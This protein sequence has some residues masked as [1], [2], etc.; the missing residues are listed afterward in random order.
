MGLLFVPYLKP[1]EKKCAK[2]IFKRNRGMGEI[3]LS[4]DDI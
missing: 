2:E 3:A 4:G 1:D